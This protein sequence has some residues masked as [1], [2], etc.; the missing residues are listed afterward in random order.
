MTQRSRLPL[1]LAAAL[2]ALTAC[3]VAQPASADDLK[4]S[5]ANSAFA[6]V[7]PVSG[8]SPLP[9][10]CG[11]PE[12]SV[13]KLR[14]NTEVIPMVAHDPTKPG[15]L[16]SVYQQDRWSRYGGN[17]TGVAVSDDY[18]RNWKV[19]RNYP[20]FSRCNGGDYDVTTDHWVT[21]TPSG[22]AV[23][24]SLSLNRDDTTAIQVSR[25]GDGGLNWEAPVTLRRDEPTDTQW[26]FNDRPAVTAD[27]Y[28]SG[29]VYVVWDRVDDQSTDTEE[30]WVQPIYLAKSTDDGRTW[31]S[32]KVYDVPRNSGVIGTQLVPLPDGTLLITMQ[33]LTGDDAWAQVIRSTDG[34][35]TWSQPTMSFPTPQ[36][37]SVPIP[38][39]DDPTARIRSASLPLLA[40]RPGSREVH[41]VWPSTEFSSDGTFHVAYSRSIDGGLTWS[42]PVR[43]DKTPS[44]SATV[45][46]VAAS[47]DGR[48][49]VTY[50]DFR[51]NQP[52]PDK[53]Q[54]DV[55]AVTCARNCAQ[56]GSWSEQHIEGPFD[57]RRMP[58]TGAGLMIGDYTG[59]VS[60]PSGFVA[61]Y[62][63][64]TSDTTNPV[65]LHS[66]LFQ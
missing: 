33:Y 10:D 56:P 41:A 55:W 7:S 57:S 13:W 46:I 8:L 58:M 37:G 26:I 28:R 52:S 3:A 14:P 54:T 62:N 2:A 15:H 51:N 64:T 23:A 35:K 29:V 59:L 32:A 30:N 53:L 6:S 42:T 20:A 19:P 34:G 65:D 16:V 49:A 21:I 5:A 45:P 61:V 24:A 17:G 12:D 40:T 9:A 44:G 38:D 63:V 66:A 1:L 27:P 22:A 50:Y 39:P 31:Q 60:T 36:A 25:S 47:P 4:E 11:L 48:V 43:I 18:G